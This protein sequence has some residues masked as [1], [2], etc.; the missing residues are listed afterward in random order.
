MMAMGCLPI[1][2]RSLSMSAVTA[3]VAVVCSFGGLYIGGLC[4]PQVLRRSAR[5]VAL[6][7]QLW[8]ITL[9]NELAVFVA[10]APLAALLA[11]VL[12]R[13]G[14]FIGASA[15][16]GIASLIG[17]V[18]KHL[19]WRDLLR[20]QVSAMQRL[21][22]CAAIGESPDSGLLIDEFLVDA[23]SLVLSDR[24]RIWLYNESDTLLDCVREAPPRQS[25]SSVGTVKRMGEELVGRVA[26]RR[27]AMIVADARR[28]ARHTLYT[29][30]DRQKTNI[31]PV[32]QLIVPLSANNEILGV[33]EFE[34]SQWGA[35]GT[36]DRDRIQCLATLVAVGLAN[37]RRHQ[38]VVQLAATD[39]LT[40]LYNKRHVMS[41]LSDEIYRAARYGHTLSILMMDIDGFKNYNDTY[42][43][44]QGD[45]L[46]TQLAQCVR[47]SIRSSD[48]AGRYGGDEF[49]VIMPE[50][51][52]QAACLTAE[53]I[54]QRIEATPFPGSPRTHG[55]LP[56]SFADCFPETADNWARKTVSIGVAN[57]PSDAND[58]VLLI[59]LADNALYQAKYCGRNRV[60]AAR[61]WESAAH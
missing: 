11:F 3:V 59:S 39:G 17:L 22:E 23:R 21:T 10:G 58:S 48:H 61:E 15:A 25:G 35:F 14:G 31:G 49:I 51:G 45:T 56:P 24:L 44:P 34:R 37:I 30:N 6:G 55:S 57:Y 53:R 12:L 32:S 1:I 38:D 40:G 43:H 27:S 13:D 20:R 42:G 47:D 19:V 52:K 60:V 28:D 50:T 16:V 2:G 33:I 29:L 36:A 8:R 18:A 46:L 5:S 54:R 4:I 7:D 41:V 26:E 9:T